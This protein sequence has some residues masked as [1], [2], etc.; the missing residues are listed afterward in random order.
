MLKRTLTAL[1][2]V[3]LLPLMAACG[4]QSSQAPSSSSS[5]S[6]GSSSGGSAHAHLTWQA[7]ALG[8]GWYQQAEGLAQ[9]IQKQVPG[10]TIKVVPGGGLANVAAVNADK[11]DIAWGLPPFDAAGVQGHPPFKQKL[12]NFSSIA[13]GFGVVDIHFFVAANSKIKSIDQIFKDHMPIRIAVPQPGSSDQW[14][15]ERMLAYYHVND[16]TIRSWGGSVFNGSYT[17]IVNQYKDRNVDAVFVNL[18]IPGSMITEA[19]AG[20][21]IRFLPMSPGLI[22]YLTQYNLEAAKIPAGS[23]PKAENGNQAIATVAMPSEILVNN[24]VPKNIVSAITTA[25]IKNVAAVRKV[26]PSFAT[27]DINK[28]PDTGV[29]P[30]APGAKAAYSKAGISTP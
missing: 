27:F 18:G 13:T 3:V 26:H 9:I 21:K 28:A 11:T 19:D 22:K 4:A 29:V 10:L 1:A 2:L 24:K 5:G 6:S 17:D 16:Q 20:R 23:Y 7:G 30:L 14:V 8:G 15:F 25:L 12:S